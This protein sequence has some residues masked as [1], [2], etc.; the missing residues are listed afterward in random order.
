MSF[1]KDFVQV[2]LRNAE[3]RLK[4]HGTRIWETVKCFTGDMTAILLVSF[5]LFVEFSKT[6]GVNESWYSVS[7]VFMMILFVTGIFIS[8]SA[9]FHVRGEY[10]R[11]LEAIAEVN[12]AQWYLGFDT[13]VPLERRW[14]KDDSHLMLERHYKEK[15]NFRKEEDWVKSSMQ[16]SWKNL[17]TAL[18]GFA[19]LFWGFATIFVSAMALMFGAH[20]FFGLTVSLGIPIVGFGLL[21]FICTIEHYLYTQIE[22]RA[23]L[24]VRGRF[25][26]KLFAVFAFA[27]VATYVVWV[28]LILLNVDF[29]QF[30]T[31]LGVIYG[32]CLMGLGLFLIHR[33][34]KE[35]KKRFKATATVIDVCTEE[36]STDAGSFAEIPIFQFLDAKTAKH[37]T[38]RYTWPEKGVKTHYKIGQRV[39][40]LYD[41]ELPARDVRVDSF[42]HN[43]LDFVV[44]TAGGAIAWLVSLLF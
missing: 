29:S 41:P 31:Y 33:R 19:I 15:D 38:A 20:S 5:L 8:I 23:R 34:Q 35:L 4:E 32:A 18:S 30:L 44:L 16:I 42:W 28:L 40:V 39:H 21:L 27:V 17:R 3:E 43:H 6:G 10:Q 13:T 9:W 7:L 12:K 14:F 2:S 24:N 1:D 36:E 22:L 11:Q 25:L 37:V 26:R